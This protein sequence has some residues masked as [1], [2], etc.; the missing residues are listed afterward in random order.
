MFRNPV[1]IVLYL[2]FLLMMLLIFLVLLKT[3]RR[4]EILVTGGKAFMFR[5][6][7]KSRIT[8]A[9][10]EKILVHRD[11]GGQ[12]ENIDLQIGRGRERLIDYSDMEELLGVL[13]EN[14]PTASYSEK[15]GFWRANSPVFAV[16]IS[17]GV[18]F[19]VLVLMGVSKAIIG[20]GRGFNL[21]LIAV[22]G[23]FIIYHRIWK[24]RL[25]EDYK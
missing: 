6:A 21:F 8:L 9:L 20:P 1:G 18:A 12:L 2:F 3:M 25:A 7:R 5:G 11:R 15:K 23:G 19:L 14:C 16:L 13:K 17:F 22:N 4:H 24:K 10:V